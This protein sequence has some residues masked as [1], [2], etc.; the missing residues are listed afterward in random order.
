MEF[1]QDIDFLLDEFK[2]EKFIGS[3]MMR[4]TICQVLIKTTVQ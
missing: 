2:G 4:P 3:G 1:C